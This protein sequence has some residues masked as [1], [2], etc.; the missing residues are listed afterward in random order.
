MA[1]LR[2][3]LGLSGRKE[4]NVPILVSTN[5]SKASRI[6]V[7]FG[8]PNQDLGIWAYR[9]IG[10][11]GINAGSAVPLAEYVLHQQSS[12][13]EETSE[14]RKP[15]SD[16]ALVIANTG[17]LIWHAAGRKAITLPNWMALTRRSAVDPPPRMTYRNKIPDNESWQDHVECVFD[18]ILAARGKLVRAD[19]KI[20]V[21]GIAEGGLGAV[22]YLRSECTLPH[23][24][25]YRSSCILTDW[26]CCQ[27]PSGIATSLPWSSATLSTTKASRSLTRVVTAAVKRETRS[28]GS[29]SLVAG[30]TSSLR[31]L[32]VCLSLVLMN[33]AVT[34]SLLV[35]L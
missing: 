35:R 32:V 29:C 23:F 25:Y 16:T 13:E 6:I 18:E 14:R 9:C 24:P 3:P 20:D 27:G 17:Q 2:L 11:D 5:L 28:V 15:S 34:A 19:A 4:Q 30:H 31:S 8:E 10:A 7:V 33:M 22:R 12:H 26:L 1:T 21:V